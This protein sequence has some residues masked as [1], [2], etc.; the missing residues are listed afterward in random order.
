MSAQRKAKAFAKKMWRLVEVHI[1]FAIS[2]FAGNA[3]VKHAV[4]VSKSQDKRQKVAVERALPLLVDLEPC[5]IEK[6][7]ASQKKQTPS[8]EWLFL[9]PQLRRAWLCQPSWLTSFGEPPRLAFNLFQ[10]L[11]PLRI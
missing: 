4:A 7:L 1:F 11:T 5:A 3:V 10:E 9:F 8:K 2:I 6:G